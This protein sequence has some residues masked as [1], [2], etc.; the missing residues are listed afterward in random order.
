M[1]YPVYMNSILSQLTLYTLV[2]F[3][4]IN[5]ATDPANSEN[6]IIEE[7]TFPKI[8]FEILANVDTTI[9]GAQGTRLFIE[10]ETFQFTDG[11]P[12]AGTIKIDLQEYYKKS[13]I[14][15][16]NLSTESNGKLLETGGMLNITATADGKKLE[17][18]PDKRIVVHFLKSED[19]YQP[20]NLFYA[21]NNATDTSASN[22]EIDTVSLVKRTLKL[23][24]YGWWHPSFDDSTNYNF[25]P[26]NFVDT[27]YY[28]N[29]IDFYVSS[30]NF[31]DLT[32]KEVE[33]NMNTN[34][35]EFFNMFND[36]GVE[37][38]MKISTEGFIQ[39]PKVTSKVSNEI[40]QEIIKF[41]KG[42]PQLEPGKNKFGT[43]IERQGILFIQGGEIVPLYKTR[44][45]Y[46]KSFDQKYAG[47][48]N[49]PIK[50]IDDAELEY[51]IFS[52]G[53]LGW[54]NCDRYLEEDQ[55]IDYIVKTPETPDTKLKM[56]FSNN[57]SLLMVDAVNGNYQFK[58]VPIG[59][60]ATIV[61]I[62]NTNGKF[63][64]AFQEVTISST[65]Q[66]NLEF[67]ETTLAELREELEKLN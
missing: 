11:T 21:D 23:G 38:E 47:Y 49:N 24:G 4:F 41:L 66:T 48:E 62:R 16:A 46:L 9:F 37:C 50:N 56:V 20:M 25:I 55:T 59:R 35:Y 19:S 18:K 63:E 17:I 12:A 1:K 15:L 27:G 3:L 28:W 65:L 10:K 45:E 60:V 34:N 67:K 32:K 52:V 58:G 13:D 22:W 53:K 42:L 61:A 6:F 14:A 8:E 29:P 7:I 5:C 54:I 40:K 43:I 33:N 26:K 64:T 51:Y 36:F 30:Y 31:S 44:E 39:N 2:S 57:N